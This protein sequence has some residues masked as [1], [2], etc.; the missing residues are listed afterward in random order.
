MNPLLVTAT[1]E[2]TGKTAV[3]LAIARLARER[4]RSVGYLK[5]KG[6]RLESTAGT[7]FDTDPELGVDL[8]GLDADPTDLEPIVYSPTFVDQVLKGRED[9]AEL[10]ERV[11]RAFDAQADD[12]EFVVCEGDMTTGGIVDLTDPEI[13]DELD[14]D[15]LLVARYEGPRDPD[16]VVDAAD[17]IGDRLAGV[18]FNGVADA[19][20]DYVETTLVP[21]L[22]GRGIPVVGVVPRAADLAG[23]SVGTLAEELGAELLTDVPTDG[24]VERFVVGAMGGDTALRYFR[25]TKDAAVITGGDRSDVHVAAL[26]ASGVRCL[27]L[28]GGVRPSGS[29]LGTAAE[30]GIPVMLVQSDTRVATERAEAVVRSGRTRSER[31]VSRMEDLLAEHADVDALLE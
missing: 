7:A 22:E 1:E 18:V 14:A 3:A 29:V 24:T 5:P 21:F 31:T 23:V 13:A 9:P 17:R 26:E 15:V 25:R 4:G 11:R 28:T 12:A 2:S 27:V 19:D 10:R 8:L 16:A 30:R 6:T 20:F